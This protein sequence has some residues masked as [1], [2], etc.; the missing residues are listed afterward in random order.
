MLSL[1]AVSLLLL[2]GAAS[3]CPKACKPVMLSQWPNNGYRASLSVTAPMN[4]RGQ[5]PFRVNMFFD[6]APKKVENLSIRG[7]SINMAKSKLNGK[8]LSLLFRPDQR[9]RKG[10]TVSIYQLS[11]LHELRTFTHTE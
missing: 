4:Y 5:R 9:I 1:I 2:H 11:Y 6:K 3:M 7:G 8:K 10:S